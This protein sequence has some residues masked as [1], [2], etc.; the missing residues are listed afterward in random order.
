MP[1]YSYIYGEAYYYSQQIFDL[2]DEVERERE[3]LRGKKLLITSFAIDLKNK[4]LN[5]PRPLRELR[6]TPY[7]IKDTFYN[8]NGT[9]M[10]ADDTG[11]V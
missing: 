8:K 3:E 6:D 1:H 5:I 2:I 7:K 9:V 4:I 10:V 11:R